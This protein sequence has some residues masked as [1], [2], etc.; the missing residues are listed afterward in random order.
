MNVLLSPYFL[1]FLCFLL[2]RSSGDQIQGQSFPSVDLVVGHHLLCGFL[3]FPAGPEYLV[4]KSFEV[5]V[6]K[7]S[8]VYMD[9]SY[10]ESQELTIATYVDTCNYE[11]G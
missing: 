1:V 2:V 7:W 3:F 10:G 5:G 8:M 11:L 4:F 9:H 6:K